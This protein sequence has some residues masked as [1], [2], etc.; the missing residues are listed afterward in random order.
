MKKQKIRSGTM[1]I[2]GPGGTTMFR[3][4]DVTVEPL[5][6]NE[7]D[8]LGV[9]DPDRVTV[10]RELL[11]TALLALDAMDWE[12]E[13]DELEALLEPPAKRDSHD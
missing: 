13:R 9:V 4:G 3:V 5:N 11:K 7:P 1:T 12:D 2:E 6:P 8:K 10:P